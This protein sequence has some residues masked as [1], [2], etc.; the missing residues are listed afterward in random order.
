MIPILYD[1]SEQSFTSLGLGALSDAVSCTVK[2]VLNGQFELELQYPVSGRRY[3]DIK[4]SN[5]IKAVAEKN[6]SAQLFDIHTISKPL[7]GIITVY[8]SHVSSRKQFIPIM[9][10]L[11]TDIVTAFQTIKAH[12]AESNPFTLWTD[13]TTRANFILKQP[14]SLGQVLGGMEG[15]ILDTYRGEYEFDNWTIKLWNRRGQD[16]GVTL[17]YGKNITSIEQE[18]SIASTIT[19]ICPF[20]SDADGNTITLSE[21]VIESEKAANFPFRRTIVKD[22]SND[23]DDQP[24]EA[25]LRAHT[26]SYITANN[27][28]VPEVGMDV[29]YENLSDY[30]GYEQVGTLEQVRLGD[31]I[32][33][34]FEPLDITAEA[35]V[36]ETEYNTLLDKYNKV[37]LGAVKSSLSTVINSD[38]STARMSTS[39][40]ASKVTSTLEKA[41]ADALEA[42]SGADGGNIVI[43]QNA[44]T[45]KPY[46]I[47]AM[48]TE[49][50]NT[51][52]KVLRLNDE[53]L[54]YSQNGI[55]G[56][57]TAAITGAGIV[58]TAITS[59]TLDAAR[60]AANSISVSKLTGNISNGNWKIDL[61]AGTFSIGK[62]TADSITAGTITAAV[63][64]TNLTLTNGRI[65]IQTSDETYDYIILDH[66]KSKTYISSN[67]VN[68]ENK[69]TAT[70]PNIKTTLQ[71]GGIWIR[72]TQ[73][74]VL[75]ATYQ[76]SIM[77]LYN[78]SG[79]ESV[80]LSGTSS[81]N[82]A[83]K[84]TDGHQT[85][86]LGSTGLQV[87]DSNGKINVAAS[88]ST[89]PYN[90]GRIDVYISAS[91][92]SIVRIGA[93]SAGN[94][95]ISLNDTRGTS[96]V[97]LNDGAL[98]F[99]DSSGTMRCR[100]SPT[101][102]L[103]FYNASGTATKTYG[104]S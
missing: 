40:A 98:Y 6:G 44:V 19:G 72:D 5:I 85:I 91:T 67:T 92:T 52:R 65:N 47:L 15:S 29:S 84:N 37:R 49:D 42:L 79:V 61:D 66:S 23:F 3:S 13:K 38:A 20:W 80:A 9:P 59:G 14:A 96:R 77:S 62:I 22:F 90:A 28:G 53:G 68:V 2:T 33:I 97:I 104:V 58:A 69:S 35:R 11:A 7:N 21:K 71:G 18:E 83:L 89:Y 95:T 102:G 30:E 34:Y 32:H 4:V 70:L 100:L 56:L 86:Y 101:A 48:D 8:A 78:S 64:A 60:I 17:R 45:G 55:N 57:Y 87:H 16:N 10:C 75:L 39:N 25:Q 73:T 31:T 50:V 63:T 74:N 43:R 27:I 12:S 103:T 93:T 24:T 81:G 1:S 41:F 94:G 26:Q 51:A 99:Y 82:I 54:G 88:S 36:T 76:R 46:E